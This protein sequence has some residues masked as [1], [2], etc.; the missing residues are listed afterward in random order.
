AGSNLGKARRDNDAG[1]ANG[2][3]QARGEREWN[4]QSIRHSD[5]NVTNRFAGREM[6]FDVTR[7][8]HSQCLFTA[9]SDKAFSIC[10][11][12][13]SF[14]RSNRSTLGVNH[15]VT[16]NTKEIQSASLVLFVSCG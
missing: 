9:G 1:G 3:C 8:W 16:N 2:P 4:G 13:H 11:L 12:T 5:H 10:H 15:K 14:C 6:S 7:L